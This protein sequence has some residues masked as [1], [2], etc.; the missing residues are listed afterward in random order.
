MS[1]KTVEPAA[2]PTPLA[3]VHIR[4]RHSSAAAVATTLGQL[5]IKDNYSHDDVPD[6]V[7]EENQRVIADI[8]D[9]L[10][11][12]SVLSRDEALKIIHPLRYETVDAAEGGNDLV[13]G[14]VSPV[15]GQ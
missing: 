4:K 2:E 12:K 8:I 7:V 1:M 13:E 10:T 3:R 5:W 9:A 6:T 14:E 11:N 15:S